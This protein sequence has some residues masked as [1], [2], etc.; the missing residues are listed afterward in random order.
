MEIKLKTTEKKLTKSLINQMPLANF[1]VVTEGKAI[2]WLNNVVKKAP[3]SLLIEYKG[4]YY[5]IPMDFKKG[6]VTVYR[7]IGTGWTQS[8]NFETEEKC[9][10]FWKAYRK[11]IDNVEQI[12]I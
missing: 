7:R 8:K 9:N 5:T 12:Y 4:L 6:N 11:M 3:K 2:G 1:E 10:I